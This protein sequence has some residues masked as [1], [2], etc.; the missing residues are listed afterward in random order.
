MEVIG[1]EDRTEVANER[2]DLA[3]LRPRFARTSLRSAALSN[4]GTYVRTY[5]RTYEQTNER[6]N[7]Q[8]D[9]RLYGR[10]YVQTYGRTY[11]RTDPRK[12]D[13]PLFET[14]LKT[15]RDFCGSDNGIDKSRDVWLDSSKSGWSSYSCPHG[16]SLR[17]YIFGSFFSCP[18]GGKGKYFGGFLA[19]NRV[20]GQ[21]NKGSNRTRGQ[22]E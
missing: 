8:T 6:T 21:S 19:V 20:S 11:G 22:I 5:V 18:H 1:G 16:G 12:H 14:S 15:S 3:S 7:E 9:G 13:Q 17:E 4:V 10:T 2:T